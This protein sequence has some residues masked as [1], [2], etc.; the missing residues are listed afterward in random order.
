MII[1]NLSIRS[2]GAGSQG[3]II[4]FLFSDIAFASKQRQI[5]E[6][7]GNNFGGMYNSIFFDTADCILPGVTILVGGIKLENL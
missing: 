2:A 3:L 5:L 7:E 6:A 1:E 4:G